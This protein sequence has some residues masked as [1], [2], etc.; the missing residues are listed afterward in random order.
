MVI[1]ANQIIEVPNNTHCGE[2]MSRGASVIIL[3]ASSSSGKTGESFNTVVSI[4]TVA[5]VTSNRNAVSTNEHLCTGWQWS[6][7]VPR[8]SRRAALAQST[9]P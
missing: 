1:E 8:G 9:A 6:I 3:S 4:F 2:S 7:D 5:T